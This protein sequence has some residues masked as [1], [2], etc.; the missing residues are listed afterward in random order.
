ME[1]ELIIYSVYMIFFMLLVGTIILV[2]LLS[3]KE[4]MSTFYKLFAPTCHQKISRSLC[5]FSDG[6][7]YWLG[8]CTRQGEGYISDAA[9]R[10]QVKVVY[11]SVT[12]YKMPVCAR[13]VGIYGALLFGGL[14]YPLVRDIREKSVWPAIFLILSM[15]PIGLDGGIQLVSE[16]GFL[17]FLYESTNAMRLATGAIS[18]FAAAFYAIPILVNMFGGGSMPKAPAKKDVKEEVSSPAPKK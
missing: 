4:D 7:G 13:D 8:D 1:R 16:L 11:G 10:E 2:P 18:G 14:L 5:V 6:S 17:P 9:D 12:G 15:V 3:F